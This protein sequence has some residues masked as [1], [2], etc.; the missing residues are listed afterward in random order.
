M[1]SVTGIAGTAAPVRL[2]A[3]IAREISAAV[4]NGRAA[5]WIRTMS[6]FCARRAPQVRHARRPGASRRH[7][8]AARGAAADGVVEQGG[9]VGV[10]HRL[11]GKDLGWRQ[12]GSIARKITVWPPI[13]RYCF[14]PPEPARSPRPAATRMAA[15]RS[16]FG[17][18]LN[19]GRMGCDGAAGRP[20]HSPYHAVARKNRIIPIA[21]GKAYFAAVHLQDR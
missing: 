20:A 5:S 21:V 8:P 7:W 13:V 6:G 3:S 17:I 14:G 4:T 11:H 12:N 16:G 19:C 2:A 9:V 15:V 18:G 1:V 10:Q